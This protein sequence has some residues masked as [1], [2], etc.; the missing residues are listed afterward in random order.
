MWCAFCYTRHKKLCGL[1]TGVWE[2]II[3]NVYPLSDYDVCVWIDCDVYYLTVI[4]SSVVSLPFILLP[5]YLSPLELYKFSVHNKTIHTR[6]VFVLT[7]L[8]SLFL[9]LFSTLS[10]LLFLS[11]Y[12]SQMFLT[13][14]SVTVISNTNSC[15]W[16]MWCTHAPS[17]TRS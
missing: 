12:S 14:Q 8:F 13:L 7:F 16:D 15:V 9:T 11:L 17:H 5:S 10:P 3:W 6:Q 2:I 1:I 4:F